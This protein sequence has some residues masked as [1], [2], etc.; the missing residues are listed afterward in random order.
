[1][2]FCTR[3]MRNETTLVCK[4]TPMSGLNLGPKTVCFE[5]IVCIEVFGKKMEIIVNKSGLAENCLFSCDVIV[6]A[7]WFSFLELIP[8]TSFRPRNKR[9]I[10]FK[11]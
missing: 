10:D 2:S 8:A 7:P 3:R 4:T 9:R 5:A 6:T 1:M 11:M